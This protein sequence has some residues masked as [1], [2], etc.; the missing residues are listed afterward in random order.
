RARAGLAVAGA[1]GQGPRPGCGTG[2][3]GRRWQV[4]AGLRI[5][6]LASVPGLAGP[7][8]RLRVVWQGDEL[9]ARDCSPEELLQDPGPGRPA[10]DAR[11]G[12]GQAAGSRPRT[13]ADPGSTPVPCGR[14]STG[15]SEGGEGAVASS[16]GDASVR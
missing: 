15:P 5:H 12:D 11:E 10:G 2:G 16:T 4:P 8:G 9:S 6:A 7:G 1:G 13:R 3:R 14:P